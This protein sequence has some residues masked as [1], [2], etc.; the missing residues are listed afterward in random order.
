MELDE[1]KKLRDKMEQTLFNILADFEKRTGI[2]VESQIWV[3]HY[4]RGN[5]KRE[6]IEKVEINIASKSEN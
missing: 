6:G 5:R 2:A 1:I 4:D 3:S